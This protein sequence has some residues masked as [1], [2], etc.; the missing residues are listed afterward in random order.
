MSCA[1]QNNHFNVISCFLQCFN[2][3]CEYK[4]IKWVLLPKNELAKTIL[5]VY[6]VYTQVI[7]RYLN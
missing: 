6:S 2:L 3:M 4:Y 5:A 1:V 7:F